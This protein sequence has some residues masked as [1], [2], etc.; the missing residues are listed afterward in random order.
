[1]RVCGAARADSAPAA[2]G[3]AADAAACMDISAWGSS[4]V[5]FMASTLWGEDSPCA[6]ET[7]G[8]GCASVSDKAPAAAAVASAPRASL[9]PAGI[10]WDDAPERVAAALAAAAPSLFDDV[11]G[12]AVS[13]T[14]A[15]LNHS[16]VPNVQIEAD[17]GSGHLRAIAL[18]PIGGEEELTAAYVA[19]NAPL[20]DRRTSLLNAGYDFTCSCPRCFFDADPRRVDELPASDVH[21]LAKQAQEEG[22]YSDAEALLRT[23]LA[24]PLP[25]GVAP[26]GEA[27]HGT[28]VCLLSRGEWVAAHAIWAD[29]ARRATLHGALKAQ[30]QKDS[31]FWPAEGAPCQLSMHA[32]N[33]FGDENFRFVNVGESDVAVVS[34][35]PLLTADD[36]ARAVAAAE[37]AAARRGGWTTARHYAVPTTDIP[38]HEVPGLLAWFNDSLESSIAPLLAAAYP[39]DLHS[40]NQV[41]IHDAFLVRYTADAQ[42]YLPVHSDE[43]QFS[44]T[45]ALNPRSEY[46]GGGTYF[47]DSKSVICPD[48]GHIVAFRGDTRHGGE[49]ITHG[50]RYIMAVFCYVGE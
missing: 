29:G 37:E 46:E 32:S 15:L 14:T 30:A 1:M 36:C 33:V 50:T 49:P 38:L 42:R 13:P 4:A 16:C 7:D 8:A 24:R 6:P 41:R 40:P 22:R 18:R 39:S 27:M 23:L 2:P 45:I 28:G 10:D 12:L 43:S 17:I 11:S 35:S 31:C 25:P 20:A 19:T 47:E 34:T 9:G 26:D 21:A 48:V 3:R 44:L 5:G